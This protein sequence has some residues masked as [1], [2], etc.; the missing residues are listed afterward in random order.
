MIQWSNDYSVGYKKID[1]QHQ[2]LVNILN[3]LELLLGSDE[4]SNDILFIKISDLLTKLIDYTEV[5]F[6]TE[7]EAFE[8]SDYENTQQH[9]EVHNDF[10][11]KIS[12]F[13]RDLVFGQD[14]RKITKDMHSFLVN[15]FVEHINGEDQKYVGKLKEIPTKY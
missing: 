13:L 11:I 6:K 12:D 4:I 7:E 5:H 1:K 9:I 15:W 3:D 14:I 8:V 2:G 10:I